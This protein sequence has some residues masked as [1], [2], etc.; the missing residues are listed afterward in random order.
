MSTKKTV[1]V[2]G[3]SSGIGLGIAE[4]FIKKGANVVLNGR[5]EAKLHA[6]AERLGAPD[7]TALVVGDMSSTETPTELVRVALQRFG[8]VDV[9]VNNAGHFASKPFGDYTVDDLNGFLSTHLKGTY[10]A[11]QAAITPMRRQGGGAIINI[12]TVLALR[13]VK[14]IP[15]SAP[16][17]AKGG[18]NAVTRSLAI[19]LASDN[20]RVNAISPGI[21]K[22]PLYRIK[23]DEFGKLKDMQPLGRVGEVKDIVDAVLYLADA[24]FVTGVVLPVDGGVAAGGE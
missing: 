20:I 13:G 3:A 12:T 24:D 22:T 4:A 15:S 8:R 21:I 23:N 6:A 5:N 16:A 17:A 18:M 2:T 7:Q 9:L 10:L 14:T 11:S 19:E 1:I